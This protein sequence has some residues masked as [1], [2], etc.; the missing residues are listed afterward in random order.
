MCAGDVADVVLVEQ[1]NRA[2]LRSAQAL[3]SPVEAMS[4]KTRE[5]DTLL[6]VH[7]HRR[8]A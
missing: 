5:V 6:P 1:Q 3:A 8:T 4:A 7:R 2:Q